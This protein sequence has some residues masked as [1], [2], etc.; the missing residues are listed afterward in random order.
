M[1]PTQ[2]CFLRVHAKAGKQK[3]G[4]VRI[5]LTHAMNTVIVHVS[6]RAHTQNAKACSG[7]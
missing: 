1:F 7:A 3:R 4:A 5:T 6:T 2:L